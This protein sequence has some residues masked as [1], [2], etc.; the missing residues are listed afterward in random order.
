M[1]LIQQKKLKSTV[2]K[3]FEVIT[4]HNDKL[5]PLYKNFNAAKFKQ[6]KDDLNNQIETIKKAKKV[7]LAEIVKAY[8]LFCVYFVGEAWTQLDKVV[9]E[10]HM[11]DPW[12]AV[13]GTTHKG[14]SVKTWASCLDC[15]ELH[16]LTI[17]G[18]CQVAVVLHATVHQE[19]PTHY[20][21]CLHGA[22]GPSQ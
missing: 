18:R 14:P 11:K 3:A 12:V 9:Q 17:L 20:G 8:E 6:E 15:I 19:A 21:A 4:G 22:Y 2:E 7:A 5:G 1:Q 10:M 13:N 16:K